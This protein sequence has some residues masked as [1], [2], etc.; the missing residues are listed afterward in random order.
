MGFWGESGGE[1]G[2]LLELGGPCAEAVVIRTRFPFPFALVTVLATVAAAVNEPELVRT[3]LVAVLVGV[4][5]GDVAVENMVAVFPA[6]VVVC[7]A[8]PPGFP[9]ISSPSFEGFDNH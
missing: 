5:D 1:P 8:P 7:G 2:L 9:W 6:E 3:S 4:G